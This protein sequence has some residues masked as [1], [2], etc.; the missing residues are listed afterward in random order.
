MM[1]RLN[2]REEH[3]LIPDD[4]KRALMASLYV[5]QIS[6]D[7]IVSTRYAPIQFKRRKSELH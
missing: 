3:D 1:N 2:T 7:T 5:E 4:D 6:F